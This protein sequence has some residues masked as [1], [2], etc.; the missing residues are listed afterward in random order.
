MN[1]KHWIYS[2]PQC[3]WNSYNG[4]TLKLYMHPS[5]IHHGLV[6]RISWIK[7]TM[8]PSCFPWIHHN[9]HAH[10]TDARSVMLLSYIYPAT[11]KR[12]T[13]CVSETG[14][15]TMMHMRAVQPPVSWCQLCAASH[16]PSELRSQVILLEMMFTN[17]IGLP[18][19]RF[20]TLVTKQPDE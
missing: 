18:V 15:F 16:I 9:A 4:H 8:D 10:W 1:N 19:N 11:N 6:V 3:R 7:S 5:W 17:S 20:T 12:S 13:L 2:T 14:W